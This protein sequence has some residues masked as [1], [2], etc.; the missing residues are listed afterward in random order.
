LLSLSHQSSIQL[1]G[2]GLDGLGIMIIGASGTL[3]GTKEGI[4]EHVKYRDKLK[5]IYPSI[6][7]HI[8]PILSGNHLFFVGLGKKP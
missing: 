3:S 5:G 6:S 1:D 7:V 4:W 2:L 8:H